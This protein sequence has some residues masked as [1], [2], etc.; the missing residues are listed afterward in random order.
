M[1]AAFASLRFAA[2]FGGFRFSLAFDRLPV[3][4]AFRKGAF[5]ADLCFVA[6]FRVT[7]FPGFV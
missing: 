4:A 2:A 1:A 3:A 5:F 6:F 7:R